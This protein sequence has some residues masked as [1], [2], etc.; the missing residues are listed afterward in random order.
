MEEERIAG[1]KARGLFDEGRRTSAVVE[2][3]R[4]DGEKVEGL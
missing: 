1:L 2:R 4:R 3:E